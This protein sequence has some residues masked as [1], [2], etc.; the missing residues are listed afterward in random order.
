MIFKGLVEPIGFVVSLYLRG[1]GDISDSRTGLTISGELHPL[2][3]VSLYDTIITCTDYFEVG[4]N[5]MNT[6]QVNMAMAEVLRNWD[7]FQQGEDFYEPEIADVLL[8]IRDIESGSELAGKMQEIYEF[9]FEQQL[10]FNDCL[11]IA[12]QLRNIKENESCTL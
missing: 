5:W 2:M 1:S 3:E 8:A 4:D 7:P 6:Q 12:E 9:S 11:K 10:A